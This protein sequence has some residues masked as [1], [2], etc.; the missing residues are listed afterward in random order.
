MTEINSAF[1][2]F[3]NILYNNKFE[4]YKMS[5]IA[6]ILLQEVKSEKEIEIL[7]KIYL[8]VSDMR[9]T[10]YCLGTNLLELNLNNIEY[11]DIRTNKLLEEHI[12]DIIEN[13]DRF[14]DAQV[15]FTRVI[16][17]DDSDFSLRKSLSYLKAI[18][19][20][21]VQ[22]AT[23]FKIKILKNKNEEKN[24]ILLTND[25][26]NILVQEAYSMRIVVLQEKIK[27]VIDG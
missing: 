14:I 1:N 20:K 17:Y 24:F 4:S 23:E 5:E 26:I 15:G 11:D 18:R 2:R 25:I 19:N 22:K 9:F 27:E 3:K 8:Y 10:M 7:N 13:I 21:F 6:D 12:R 16:K